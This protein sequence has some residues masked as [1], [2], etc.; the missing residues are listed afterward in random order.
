MPDDARTK[1]LVAA[2]RNLR[3]PAVVPELVAELRQKIPHLSHCLLNTATKGAS[4]SFNAISQ[5]R[6]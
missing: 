4:L 1:A 6:A 3:D 5:I 2:C